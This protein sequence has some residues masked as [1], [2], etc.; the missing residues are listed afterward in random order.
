M[1]GSWRYRRRDCPPDD[2]CKQLS[3]EDET[4]ALDEEKKSIRRYNTQQIYAVFTEVKY[5]LR[6]ACRLSRTYPQVSHRCRTIEAKCRRPYLKLNLGLSNVLLATAAAG[7]LLSLRDLVLDGLNAEVLK[8][9]T[10]N[11]VDA[12]LGTGLDGG[13]TAGNC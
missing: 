5:Y 12:E 11:S 10:L 3:A 6:T 1:M 2:E 8:S 4:I 13:E 9:V 7:D